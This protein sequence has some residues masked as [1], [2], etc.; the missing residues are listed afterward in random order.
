MEEK[1]EKIRKKNLIFLKDKDFKEVAKNIDFVS[2]LIIKKI[3][4]NKIRI[5]V[6]E[7][8]PIGVYLNDKGEEYLFCQNAHR[9]QYLYKNVHL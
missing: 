9:L 1:L 7:D 6:V 3:Y 8:L 5:N 2:S 4:P